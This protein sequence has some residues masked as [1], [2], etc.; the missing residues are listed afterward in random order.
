M[1]RWE[2]FFWGSVAIAM[3][4]VLDGCAAGKALVHACQEGLCR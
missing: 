2:K 1:N 4:I 3:I